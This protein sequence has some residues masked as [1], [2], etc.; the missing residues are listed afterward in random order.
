MKIKNITK[1]INS[2]IYIFHIVN[3]LRKILKSEKENINIYKKKITE[4]LEKLNKDIHEITEE[5][6]DVKEKFLQEHTIS[7]ER[8]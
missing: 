7:D 1:L 5:E 3:N 2:Q 6:L 8:N 4:H